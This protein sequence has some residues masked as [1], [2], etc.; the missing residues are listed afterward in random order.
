MSG[1]IGSAEAQAGEEAEVVRSVCPYVF[2]QAA[3]EAGAG[4]VFELEEL[5][6]F[7]FAVQYVAFVAV[8]EGVGGSVVQEAADQRGEGAGAGAGVAPGQA[9]GVHRR[10]RVERAVLDADPDGVVQ[11]DLLDLAAAWGA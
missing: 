11:D 7:G 1:G 9:G 8:G 5:L 2:Q 6:Q 4:L 3:V 10:G